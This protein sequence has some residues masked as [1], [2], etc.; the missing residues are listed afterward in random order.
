MR[1]QFEKAG[2]ILPGFLVGLKMAAK[3]RQTVSVPV[4]T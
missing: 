3:K 4:P 1:N 2:K